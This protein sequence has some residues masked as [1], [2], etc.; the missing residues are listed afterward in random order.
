M[1]A[2]RAARIVGDH[3]AGGELLVPAVD[4][5]LCLGAARSA[6]VPMLSP[7]PDPNSAGTDRNQA[8]EL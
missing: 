8:M 6:L 5:G 7:R 2:D 3:L 1:P 4:D